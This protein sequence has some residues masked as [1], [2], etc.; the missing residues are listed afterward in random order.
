[1]N[2]DQAKTKLAEVKQEVKDAKKAHLI[3]SPIACR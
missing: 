3:T 2:V 1:M